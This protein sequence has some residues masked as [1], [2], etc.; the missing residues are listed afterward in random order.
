M[1]DLEWLEGYAN[2]TSQQLIQLAGSYRT[3]SIVLAFEQAVQQRAASHGDSSLNEEEWTILCIEALEREVNN[4][5]YHQFFF[6]KPEYA[7]RVVAALQRI[8]CNETARITQD[9]F[10][11]LGLPS[12]FTAK[13]IEVALERDPDQSLIDALRDCC[14]HAY[15]SSGESIGDRLFEYIKRHADAIRIPHDR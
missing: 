8:G 11:V 5:G 1:S 10:R 3:D 7:P 6:N 4:G 2:Q 15:Y 14:D 13:D 12:D 9:A